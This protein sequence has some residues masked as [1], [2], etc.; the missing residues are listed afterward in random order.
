MDWGRLV[1]ADGSIGLFEVRVTNATLGA[2]KGYFITADDF[3]GKKAW[4]RSRLAEG[5]PWSQGLS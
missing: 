3:V 2:Y 1:L 4:V 5:G